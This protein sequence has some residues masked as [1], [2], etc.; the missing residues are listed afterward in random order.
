LWQ[1]DQ[2]LS[3]STLSKDQVTTHEG[4]TSSRSSIAVLGELA[5]QRSAVAPRSNNDNGRIQPRGQQN[6]AVQ[7]HLYRFLTF[8]RSS[9]PEVFLL[10]RTGDSYFGFHR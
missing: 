1:S 9:I 8:R 6:E 4:T 10:N 3:N 2:G 5:W 7:L